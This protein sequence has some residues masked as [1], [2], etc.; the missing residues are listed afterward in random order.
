MI[1]LNE[2]FREWRNTKATADHESPRNCRSSVFFPTF[3]LFLFFFLFYERV[4][5]ARV[6]ANKKRRWK[7]AALEIARRADQSACIKGK[8]N[9]QPTKAGG[10]GRD[11]GWNRGE[12]QKELLSL[13]LSAFPSLTFSD[14]THG[15]DVQPPGVRDIC[16]VNVLK[17]NYPRLNIKRDSEK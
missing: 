12:P 17:W 16:Q 15:R 4:A 2:R 6:R 1:S 11:N 13:L 3:F 8:N 9:N 5:S 14:A 10:T 7:R